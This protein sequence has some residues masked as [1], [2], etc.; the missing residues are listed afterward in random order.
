MPIIFLEQT[1]LRKI[2]KAYMYKDFLSHSYWLFAIMKPSYLVDSFMLN[3]NCIS[4]E[5]C[6]WMFITTLLMIIDKTWKQSK[7][8]SVSEWINKLGYIQTM[9]HY[10]EGKRNELLSHERT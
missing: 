2:I 8:P 4:H 7:Y 10:L 1:L 9:E 3:F 6:K 5:I